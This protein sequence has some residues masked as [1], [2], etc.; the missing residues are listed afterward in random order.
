MHRRIPQTLGHRTHPP[1]F[2]Q[3]LPRQYHPLPPQPLPQPLLRLPLKPPPQRPLANL[4]NSRHRLHTKTAPHRQL[5]PLPFP[6]SQL[7]DSH[8]SYPGPD[9]PHT[10]TSHSSAGHQLL[11]RSAPTT[12]NLPLC[13]PKPSS[14]NGQTVHPPPHPHTTSLPIAIKAE[15]LP[16]PGH[17]LSTTAPNPTQSPPPTNDISC[18]RPAAARHQSNRA[19][20][21]PARILSGKTTRQNWILV[22]NWRPVG[23]RRPGPSTTCPR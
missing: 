14:N 1:T 9:L 22:E 12:I 11:P 23:S 17:S 7:H 4:Q 18:R 8:S 21:P 19:P 3:P 16:H 6:N 5:Q 15:P 2:P 13:L 20:A 10:A